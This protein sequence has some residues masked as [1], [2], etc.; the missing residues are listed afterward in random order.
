MQAGSLL[1]EFK[2]A[3]KPDKPVVH[4][5]VFRLLGLG[6]IFVLQIVLARMMGPKNYGDY[7]VIITAVNLLL[8]VSMF[9]F[10]SSILRFLPSSISK[11]DSASANGFVKFSN[12]IILILALICSVAI[13]I[14]LLSKSK[15]FNI[16][17]SEG[18][19]W[20][21][22]LLPFMA[23]TNQASAVLRSLRMVKLS[24]LPAYFLFPVLMALSC[25]YYYSTYNK[26]TVDAA[27]LINLGITAA[28][29]IYINRK[30]GKIMK[31]VIEPVE[32]T[33]NKK[34]W[35]SVSSVL[36]M[37]TA[38]D[39]MLKQSD[40]LMVSY[41][42]GNTQAGVYSVSAKL[43]TL[44]SLGLS[45]ADYVIMPKISSLYESK[46]FTKL[47]KMIRSASFQ[48]L[49]ISLPVIIGMLLFGRT[50]LGFFGKA[51][52]DAYWP[53]VILLIGQLINAGTG[54]VGGLLTMTGHQ[55]MFFSFYAIAIV[56]QFVLNSILIKFVGITGAA[57][58]S[59]IGLIFLNISAYLYVRK[60]LRIRASIF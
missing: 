37:T 36:F 55:K 15:K 22:F 14:F 38:M 58:G 6:L 4:A 10:D 28:I 32:P 19:F 56:I 43:A 9:G 59:S 17:F 57:I 23:F 26:L 18:L 8:V 49:S 54:M 40:I 60:R 53:L 29:C 30:A 3:G 47:Q 46:Q 1:D 39:L 42:L 25:W 51:Y 7:T 52:T 50:I 41:F 33:F 35:V 16:G 24:L 11:G 48:I 12:R 5:L 34:L 27:M 13:F 45:V 31:D 21:V 44:A 20:A 2:K